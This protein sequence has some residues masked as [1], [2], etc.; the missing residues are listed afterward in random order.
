MVV[1][2]AERIEV[3]GRAFELVAERRTGVAVYRGD[4]VYLRLGHASVA[5]VGVQRRLSDQG[6]P[7]PTLLGVGE[8][9]GSPY[10]VEASV[11]PHTLG[12]LMDEQAG[13]GA[14]IGTELFAT[15]ADLLLRWA[16]A[17]LTGD[18][19]PWRSADLAGLL[20]V[21]RVVEN[22]PDLAEPV[23]ASFEQAAG[24]LR[25]VP[26]ALQHDDL[27]AFNMCAGGV[28]DLEGVAWAA[29]GY[30][31]T[32]AL[33][34]PALA[35]GRWQDDRLAL[36]WFTPAQVRGV[37][38]RLDD[39]FAGASAPPPSSLLDA[40]LVCRALH[41]CSHVHRDAAVQTARVDMLARLLPPFLDTGRLPL[42]PV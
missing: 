36:A 10:F 37:L 14:E 11:G 20:G 21:A 7:V 38:A 4:G 24:L 25:D 17:Q 1:V 33:F 3:E 29:A 9:D 8:H 5:E 27:H 23:R 19:R 12:D 34:E 26:G 16:G 22:E 2:A 28:I 31:V 13:G 6:Y 18:R 40:Y 30:D 35:E 41:R 39:E 15:F 42:G 32:T